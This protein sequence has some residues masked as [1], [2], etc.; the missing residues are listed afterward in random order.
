MT[1]L[2]QLTDSRQFQL[3]ETFVK[4]RSGS[5]HHADKSRTDFNGS[6]VAC[7]NLNDVDVDYRCSRFNWA[8]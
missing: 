5:I 1:I 2:T 7:I 4:T 8:F 3:A 6:I